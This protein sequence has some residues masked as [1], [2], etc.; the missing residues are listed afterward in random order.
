MNERTDERIKTVDLLAHEVLQ[1]GALAGALSSHHCDLRQVKITALPD[2]AEGVLQPVHQRDE[3]L[4]ASVT[5]DDG[6]W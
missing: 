4:H 5:H 2:G 3:I 1:H 6:D